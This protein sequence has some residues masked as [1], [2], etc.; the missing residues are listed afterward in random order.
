VEEDDD[1]KEGGCDD[2]KGED[3][4]IAVCEYQVTFLVDICRLWCQ[5]N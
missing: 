1:D 2:D 3:E 4:V 5:R